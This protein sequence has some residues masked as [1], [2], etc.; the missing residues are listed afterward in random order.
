MRPVNFPL[1]S[2]YYLH[3][4][5]P[6]RDIGNYHFFRGERYPT[7]WSFDYNYLD[8]LR[9][10]FLRMAIYH[11]GETTT[12]KNQSTQ[13]DLKLVIYLA[14]LI[15]EF[16]YQTSISYKDIPHPLE[17]MS[18][19]KRTFAIKPPSQHTINCEINL[20][21][22]VWMCLESVSLEGIPIY[23]AFVEI[24]LELQLVLLAFAKV[25]GN[26]KNASI[27]ILNAQ[28]QKINRLLGNKNTNPFSQ[29][30]S[31]YTYLFI[32]RCIELMLAEDQKNKDKTKGSF[33]KEL[34]MPMVK[35]RMK[36]VQSMIN[37][38]LSR[39]VQSPDGRIVKLGKTGRRIEKK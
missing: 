20:W 17:Q 36:L 25:E 3:Y 24:V 39:Y 9:A 2:A 30:K 26:P 35:A 21:L 5:C 7:P 8:E 10:I 13:L 19:V 32:K 11:L 31:P 23:I 28:R 6:E 22:K 38:R 16:D 34:Y 33:T 12:I 4:D 15:K 29:A 1:H 27:D 14:I 37:S 18:Q